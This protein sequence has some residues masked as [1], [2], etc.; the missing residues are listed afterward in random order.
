MKISMIG[1]A[2]ASHADYSDLVLC[3][4]WI[5]FAV[6]IFLSLPFAARATWQ[7]RT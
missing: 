2:V 5:I 1:Y 3:R 6:T 7:N 4:V